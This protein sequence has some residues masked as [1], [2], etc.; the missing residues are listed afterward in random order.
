MEAISQDCQVTAVRGHYWH[1]A[2]GRWQVGHYSVSHN[3][4]V[5]L[6]LFLVIPNLANTVCSSNDILTYLD[7]IRLPELSEQDWNII[8]SLYK[9]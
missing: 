2:S 3:C 8:D 5:C 1:L 7:G 6:L 4:R 9:K